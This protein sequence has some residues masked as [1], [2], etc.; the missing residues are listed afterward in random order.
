ML[1][2]DAWR[3][4]ALVHVVRVWRAPAVQTGGRE[5]PG[6]RRY[7]AGAPKAT[8]CAPACKPAPAIAIAEAAAAATAAPSSS[9]QAS[10]ATVADAAA[11]STA[12]AAS[13][14][15]GPLRRG[16]AVLR[17]SLPR[18]LVWLLQGRLGALQLATA[19]ATLRHGRS[20]RGPPHRMPGAGA[21]CRRDSRGDSSAATAVAPAGADAP[22]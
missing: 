21:T 5:V 2:S 17:P 22:S 6:V 7:T 14:A 20:Q 15:T 3:L 8:A 19:P 4:R 11:G 1:E 12:A 16:T 9:R 10:A 13:L 18:P